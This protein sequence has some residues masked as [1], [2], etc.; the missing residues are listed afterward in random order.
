MEEEPPRLWYLQVSPEG[1]AY[2][3]RFIAGSGDPEEFVQFLWSPKRLRDVLFAL[4]PKAWCQR[5]DMKDGLGTPV[6]EVTREGERS[7]GVVWEGLR[8]LAAKDS[9]GFGLGP[10]TKGNLAAA[11]SS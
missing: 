6:H 9:V 10:R 1:G 5:I 2:S 8:H 11:L 3:L 4:E 7:A